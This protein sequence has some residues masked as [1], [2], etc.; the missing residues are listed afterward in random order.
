MSVEQ[1]IHERWSMYRPLTDLVSAAKLY[2]GYVPERDSSGA[3]IDIPY[4]SMLANPKQTV[5]RTS[6]GNIITNGTVSFSIW[7]ASFA[8][9]KQIIAEVVDYF[10]RAT[11]DWS[12]GKMLDMKPG[13]ESYEEDEERDS[14]WMGTLDF[15]FLLL[16]TIG[17]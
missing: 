7:A 9:V 5:T 6:G 15:E 16:Q 10:N 13:L 8:A 4:V 12:Q 17:T 3:E 1:A 11:F 14:I 2:T